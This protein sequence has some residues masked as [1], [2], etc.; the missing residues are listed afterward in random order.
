MIRCTRKQV[1]RVTGVLLASLLLRVAIPAGYMPASMD[2]GWF[3]KLCPDGI[4]A[5]VMMALLGHEHAHHDD[6]NS[7]FAQCEWGGALATPL[8]PADVGDQVPKFQPAALAIASDT[9][10]H[11]SL[12]VYTTRQRSPPKSCCP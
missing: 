12:S 3:V 11:S 10:E 4:P 2:D 8:L 9:I 6:A 7:G 5:E 1:N